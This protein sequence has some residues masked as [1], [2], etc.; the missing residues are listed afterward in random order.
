M[1]Q[2]HPVATTFVAE[3]GLHLRNTF[4]PSNKDK[5]DTS[6]HVSNA[7]SR[8]AIILSMLGTFLILWWNLR[9][10]NSLNKEVKLLFNDL[11][12]GLTG[13]LETKT[14]FIE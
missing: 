12:N 3:I 4:Q 10:L 9:G 7:L 13:T 2:Y 14:K 6:K 1:K 11:D 8:E 5:V